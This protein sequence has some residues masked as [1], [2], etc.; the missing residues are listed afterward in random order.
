MELQLSEQAYEELLDQTVDMI[1]V[2]DQAGAIRYENQSAKRITGYEPGERTGEN[3]FNHI[4]PQDIEKA[5]ES[6][7]E[8]IDASGD[9]TT[10]SVELRLT[11]KDGS[12]VWVESRASNQTTSML[13]GYVISSRDITQRK[14]YEQTL[15]HERD[16]LERFA[17]I[18]S[19]DLRNPLNVIDGRLALAHDECESE[20][21]DAM[22]SAVDRM[23][24]LIEDLLQLARES[25]ADPQMDAVNLQKTIDRCRQNID[26]KAATLSIET[27]QTIVADESQLQ[28]VLENLF[29]NAVEHGGD[30]VTITVGALDDGFFVED[31]GAG[32]S[33][34]TR[35]SILDYGYST[36]PDGTGFG[37]S[38]VNEIVENHDWNLTVTESSEGGARFEISGV[39]VE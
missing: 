31:D 19:H 16:K 25:E 9:Y 6:F 2:V 18:V 23:H 3:V 10:E 8:L 7:A 36:K 28:Q 33:D 34:A 1:T 37:L 17:S 13:E 20:H 4:H 22:D 14:E 12:Y 21:L 29:R 15:K 26:L 27:D 38:I 35:D 30:T 24:E 39:T 5:K 32:L 11:R